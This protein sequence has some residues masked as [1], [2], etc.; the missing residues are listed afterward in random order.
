[1]PE[2][3]FWRLFYTM[4]S[5]AELARVNRSTGDDV[6]DLTQRRHG[7]VYSSHNRT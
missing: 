4:R 3:I 7:I 5:C 6:S 1:M 2:P